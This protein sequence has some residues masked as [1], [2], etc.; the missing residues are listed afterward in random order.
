MKKRI[1]LAFIAS[2]ATMGAAHAQTPYVGLGVT[3]T[4]HN[5]KIS[6][7][8]G[9][10]GEK[11][12]SSA[13]VFGGVEFPVQQGMP[14][15]GVELGYVDLPSVTANYSIGT[16]AGRV[17]TDGS[18]YYVAGKASVPMNE[19]FE[20]YGKLGVGH[21]R[22]KVSNASFNVG[23]RSKTEA[24]GALGA[25][26]NLAP[27]WGVVLEYERFGKSKDI[28]AKADSWTLGARYSF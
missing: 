4:D 2:A 6:G 23:D 28:G 17:T 16:T 13:K 11:W 20:F 27:Q 5:Y 18:R 10:S 12:K 3:S 19:Q 25:Q 21:N 26:W 1:L 7:A 8:T 9:V 14:K 24:Y 15:F 22:T